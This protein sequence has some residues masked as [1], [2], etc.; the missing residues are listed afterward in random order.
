MTRNRKK[1]DD[2]ID[3]QRA[4]EEALGV[5][6]ITYRTKGEID[7]LSDFHLA[8]NEENRLVVKWDQLTEKLRASYWGHFERCR[9]CRERFNQA[10][11]AKKIS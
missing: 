1:K 11:A 7:R 9:D 10:L 4:L 3:L 6:L 8:P 5:E 2:L